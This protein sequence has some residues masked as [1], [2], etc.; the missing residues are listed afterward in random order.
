[1]KYLCVSDW[2]LRPDRPL[3]RT[4]IDWME[5][6]RQNIREVVALANKNE[7][8]IL[9]AGDIFDAPRMPPN[10]ITLLLQEL[11]NLNGKMYLIGGN[12]S[13]QYH[14]QEFLMESSLGIL[15]CMDSPKIEYLECTD[16]SEDGRFEQWVK[17]N[18]QDIAIIHTLTFKKESD[19]MFGMRAVSAQSLLDKFSD[20]T[21][22]ITGDN[23]TSF[24]YD[25]STDE[26]DRYV[27]NPGCLNIQTADHKD[28]DPCVYLIDTE[29]NKRPV[30]IP[31]TPYHECVTDNHLVEKRERDDR[32]SAFIDAANKGG[33]VK[34]N[35]DDNLANAIIGEDEAVITIFD[36]L[37]EENV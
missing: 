22:L 13:I 10:V 34:L 11:Q 12:H 32:I 19:I 30:K 33:K 3:C 18:G 37:K 35:F 23:H 28:Y 14:K 36:E 25:G 8:H 4:D 24:V 7:A 5:T 17:K 27:I 29:S 31:L 6:Q 2:H 9:N 15:A 16:S 21:Y 20:Y 26:R 1:M